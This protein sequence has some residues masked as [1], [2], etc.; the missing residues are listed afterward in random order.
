M[1]LRFALGWLELGSYMESEEEL[2]RIAPESWLHPDVLEVRWESCARRQ[3][4]ADA[5]ELA[6]LLQEL[7][8]KR[9]SAWLYYA[10]SLHR[11]E[12]TQDAFDHL[13]AGSKFF[14]EPRMAYNLARYSCRLGRVEEGCLW[15]EKALEIGEKKIKEKA[16]A[17]PEF[18][19]LWD[20]MWKA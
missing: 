2:A 13:L 10:E 20:K 8:P 3:R 14:R 18:V 7:S 4:W 17:E 1:H 15:L 12:R 6:R 5:F 9:A 16:L 11:M 19:H